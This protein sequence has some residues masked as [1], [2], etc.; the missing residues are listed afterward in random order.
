MPVIEDHHAVE[1]SHNDLIWTAVGVTELD[2]AT[3]PNGGY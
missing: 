3:A 2:L 1:G